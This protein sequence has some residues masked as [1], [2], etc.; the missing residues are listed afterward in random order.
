MTRSMTLDTPTAE[1]IEGK[2]GYRLEPWYMYMPVAVQLKA[3]SKSVFEIDELHTPDEKGFSTMRERMDWK[4]EKHGEQFL[5]LIL[6]DGE[7][8]AE[9]AAGMTEDAL[10]SWANE[11]LSMRESLNNC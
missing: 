11:H 8:W 6:E 2:D 7:E 4:A 9:F 10:H 5:R 3:P 1:E